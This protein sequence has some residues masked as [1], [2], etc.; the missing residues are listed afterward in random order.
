MKII[1][2]HS[3][4]KNFEAILIRC[5]LDG[6]VRDILATYWPGDYRGE[7]EEWRRILRMVKYPLIFVGDLNAHHTGLLNSP[8]TDSRGRLLQ[9]IMEEYNLVMISHGITYQRPHQAGSSLDVALVSTSLVGEAMWTGYTEPL[10]SDHIPG[11]LDLGKTRVKGDKYRVDWKK[12]RAAMDNVMGGG[13][14]SQGEEVRP[15]TETVDQFVSQVQGAIKCATVKVTPHT[16]AHVPYWSV[17]CQKATNSR[18]K[19]YNKWQKGRTLAQ[20]MAYKQEN[21]KCRRFLRAA[22]RQSMEEL[23][24]SLN[25]RCNIRLAW[26]L[27]HGLAGMDQ[28]TCINSAQL[29]MDHGEERALKLTEEHYT[30]LYQ[31]QSGSR[32]EDFQVPEP[33]RGNSSKL[34]QPFTMNELQAALRSRKAT[35][36]GMDGVTYTWLKSLPVAAKRKLLK[37]YNES[38]SKGEVPHQWKRGKIV[39]LPKMG[40]LLTDLTGWRPICLLSCLIK[41]MEAMINMRLLWWLETGGKLAEEQNGFRWC[42]STQD[43]LQ[44]LSA[45]IRNALEAQKSVGVLHMDIAA[46]YDSVDTT[47]LMEELQEIGVPRDRCKWFQSYLSD[48]AVTI[49]VGEHRTQEIKMQRGLMQGSV[50]SP[51]L[52]NIYGARL[53][54]QTKEKI[55][56]I[57]FV[58]FADDFQFITERTCPYETVADLEETGETFI[59]V[60]QNN[61]LSVSKPKCIP[62]L[63]TQRRNKPTTIQLQGEILEIVPHTRVLG[64]IFDQRLT[65]AVHVQQVVDKCSKRLN[66]LRALTGIMKGLNVKRMLALYRGYVRP[67]LDYGAGAMLHISVSMR[68]KLEVIEN[69]GLRMILGSLP[70]TAIVALQAEAFETPLFLRWK[71]IHTRILAQQ[72]H[73]GRKSIVFKEVENSHA[74]RLHWAAQKERSTMHWLRKFPV[75]KQEWLPETPFWEM[76][77]GLQAG[78]AFNCPGNK[79]DWTKAQVKQMAETILQHHRDQ[80]R[81]LC[82]TDGSKTEAAVGAAFWIPMLNQKGGE[83]MEKW[84]AILTAELRAIKMVMTWVVEQGV[85]GDVAIM[86]DSKTAIQELLIHKQVNKTRRDSW[87]IRAIAADRFRESQTNFHLQWVPSHRGIQ[88][89]EVVDMLAGLAREQPRGGTQVMEFGELKQVMKTASQRYWQ[90]QWD[91]DT[92]GR[93]RHEVDPC[94][95]KGRIIWSRRDNDVFFT[96]MRLGVVKTADW[97]HLILKEGSGLC[98]RGCNESEVSEDEEDN[99]G[100][101]SVRDTLRHILMECPGLNVNRE[102]GKREMENIGGSWKISSMFENKA[103]FLVVVG[104]LRET[105]LYNRLV[106]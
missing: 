59:T 60:C 45:R 17:E 88:G 94:L 67:L 54:R 13:E 15:M 98:D 64:V 81:L 65:G 50:L 100:N 66:V 31:T 95:H 99:V 77:E 46:A 12:Y 56:L 32:V 63:H 21:A 39:L 29:I 104:F 16:T 24:Q 23:C 70:A 28:V 93:F 61:H 79:K 87:E 74:Q 57:K 22:R 51:T 5:T 76:G 75:P 68:K 97:R 90:Q 73:N 48:R 96:R 3:G 35:S 80:Q 27:V 103:R 4:E 11:I 42:R 41:L 85:Q 20:Y 25:E 106:N 92:K 30:R 49:Q 40:K 53:I 14:T 89:N 62:M 72:R 58:N 101:E 36:P 86:T 26:S 1:Y 9:T 69:K 91:S 6:K 19:A 33:E 83:S 84:S 105:G 47:I 102:R 43:C 78:L 38:W 37:M 55:P 52:W 10:G 82:Y 34:G 71:C 18:K 44:S 7:I 8:Q 2:L